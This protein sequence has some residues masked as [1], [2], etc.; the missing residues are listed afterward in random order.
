MLNNIIN[1]QVTTQV[2]LTIAENAKEKILNDQ[3]LKKEIKA[4]MAKIAGISMIQI[5]LHNKYIC[6]RRPM[7]IKQLSYTFFWLTDGNRFT[8]KYT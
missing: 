8:W 6:S 7:S 1:S 2:T 4:E 3:I 5:H